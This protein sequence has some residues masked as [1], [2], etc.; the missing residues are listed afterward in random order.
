MP[1]AHQGPPGLQ[2]KSCLCQ[3]VV[4]VK[5]STTPRLPMA[6]SVCVPPSCGFTP[7]DFPLKMQVSHL[8]KKRPKWLPMTSFFPFFIPAPGTQVSACLVRK[9]RRKEPKGLYLFTFCD[10]NQELYNLSSRRLKFKCPPPDSY[11]PDSKYTESIAI[12]IH[13]E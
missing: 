6:K 13:R 7:S 2:I 5:T 10:E 1:H 12:G 3:F 4:F 8:F 11:G 9:C